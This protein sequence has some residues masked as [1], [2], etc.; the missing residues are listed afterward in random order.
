MPVTRAIHQLWKDEVVPVRYLGMAASW[1]D[2]NPGWTYRLWTDAAIAAFV[3]ATFPDFAAIFHGYQAPICRADLGRYLILAHFGGVYADL[4]CRC[5][6][7]IESLIE[8]RRF[9]VGL[10]PD[11]HLAMGKCAERGLTRLPCPSFIASEPRHPVWDHILTHIRRSGH[12]ADPLDATGPFLL[13]RA[14]DG[15]AAPE[16]ITVAPAALL[17]PVDK[18]ACWNGQVHDIEFWERATRQAY[19]LHYWDGTWWRD[20]P[21]DDGLPHT[22]SIRLNNEAAPRVEHAPNAQ[23]LISCL[24]VTRDRTAQARVAIDCFLKQTW[25]NKELVIVT[26]APDPALIEHVRAL[27]APEI[28]LFHVHEPSPT[29]GDLRNISVERASGALICQWDD[30]DLYDPLRLQVQ[31]AVLCRT[32]AHACLLERWLMWWPDSRR[33]A[34]SRR[35]TWEGSVLCLKSAM[36]RYPSERR[37]ED[38][39][40]TEHLLGHARVALLDLPRLYVYVAHGANTF[41]PDHFEGHWPTAT[42]RFSDDRY[43]AVLEELERR[44]PL[45][46][47]RAETVFA[48]A[49]PP[50]DRVLILTLV[51]DAQAQLARHVELLA[52]LDHDPARLS[53]AF[54]EGCGRDD[55]AAVLAGMIPD[56]RRR[57]ARAELHRHGYGAPSTER[58][59]LEIMARS[60]NRLLSLALRDEDWVL[61]L[62]ADLLDYPPDLLRR[63]LAADRD[64]VAAH[65]VGP[66]GRTFDPGTYRHDGLEDPR[67][68]RD[69]IFQPP[70][71]HGRLGLDAFQHEPL[72]RVDSVGGSALL[73]RADLHR[74]G[75][76]FPPFSHHGHIDTEGLAVMAREM[77]ADCWALP[78][79]RIVSPHE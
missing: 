2:K 56:L 18:D 34:I 27:N 53:V 26:E 14:L 52:R 28:K 39:P 47:C 63:L 37:G 13:A 69:G 44:L 77:G 50:A 24:M 45:R 46:A 60:R 55:S 1:R 42:A 33:L 72:V 54:L 5:L 79:L 51:K 38:G 57:Y 78:G 8:G 29:L 66:D 23:P 62:D 32:G 73:I 25:P 36:P 22:V 35:R 49:A 74:D 20:A 76:C 19:M 6:K 9:V 17:Y 10:E 70:K 31:Y 7:P 71:G 58:R 30:D 15:F 68:L 75:L 59:R 41:G 43:D 3:E 67:H 21:A 12:L 64:I 40:V 61:W 4:D 11:S 16:T 48:A 65:R